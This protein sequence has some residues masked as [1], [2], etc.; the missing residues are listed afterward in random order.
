MQINKHLIKKFYILPGYIYKQFVTKIVCKYVYFFLVYHGKLLR[1]FG[2]I[3]P[4]IT[5]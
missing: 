4:Y 2:I 3:V 5:L 1:S